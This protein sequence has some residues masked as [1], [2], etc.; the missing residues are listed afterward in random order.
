[1]YESVHA[2]NLTLQGFYVTQD[3]HIYEEKKNNKENIWQFHARTHCVS[4]GRYS[5]TG[6]WLVLLGN[7]NHLSIIFVKN[8]SEDQKKNSYF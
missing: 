4:V 8:K 5:R 7:T 2:I 6:N 1:M 3:T